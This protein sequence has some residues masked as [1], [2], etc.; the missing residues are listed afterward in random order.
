MPYAA[1]LGETFKTR[2]DVDTVSQQV[3]TFCDHVAE[4]DTDP[5]LDASIGRDIQVATIH[6]ALD[7]EG[8]THGVHDRGKL[9]EDAVASGFYDSSTM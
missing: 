5:E 7:I 3:L 2:R 9:D 1:R 6:P 8:T 4:I